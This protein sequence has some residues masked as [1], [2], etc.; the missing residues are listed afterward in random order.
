MAME[1]FAL[2]FAPWIEVIKPVALREK[3]IKNLNKG[4]EK[5]S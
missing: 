3:M 2:S 5:Y 4:L 1:Q